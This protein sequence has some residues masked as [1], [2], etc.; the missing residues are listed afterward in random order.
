MFEYVRG[1]RFFRR[2]VYDR[3]GLKAN[4]RKRLNKRDVFRR[5]VLEWVPSLPA[6]AGEVEYDLEDT[7]QIRE[8]VFHEALETWGK[9]ENWIKMKKLWDMERDELSTKRLAHEAK[10]EMWMEQIMYADAWIK[11]LKS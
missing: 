1:M 6:A 7:A 10:S 5:F 2:Q 11:A 4:D 8:S 9:K 3:I